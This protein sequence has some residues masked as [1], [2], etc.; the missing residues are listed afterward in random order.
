ME[1]PMKRLIPLTCLLAFSIGVASAAPRPRAR[2]PASAEEFAAL[3]ETLREE[4]ERFAESH[5]DAGP[6]PSE[7]MSRVRYSEASIPHLKDVLPARHGEPLVEKYVRYQLLLPLTHAGGETL[8]KLKTPLM[9]LVED[10][11]GYKQMPRWPSGM[12]RDLDAVER[13]SEAGRKEARRR[14]REALDKKRRAEREVIRHNRMTKALTDT[15]KQ[16]LVM[17][18]DEEADQ[19]LIAALAREEKQGLEDWHRTL[20]VIRDEA[21]RMDADRAKDFYKALKDLGFSRGHK[22]AYADPTEPKYNEKGNSG[23]ARGRPEYFAVHTLKAVNLLAT[24]AR[25]PA[26]KVPHTKKPKRKRGR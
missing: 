25:E 10:S 22:R 19:W 11:G 1:F 2:V 7:A 17:M 13:S 24:A 3:V 21:V 5:S 23:F 20:A 12:L 14:Q 4:G 6:R 18:A 9:K 16:L 8:R 15:L 26:V